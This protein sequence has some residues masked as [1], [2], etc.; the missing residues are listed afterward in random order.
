MAGRLDGRRPAGFG[1]L[2]KQTVEESCLMCDGI[3]H[4]MIAF[5][6][7]KSFG[8]MFSHLCHSLWHHG[9]LSCTPV[10]YVAVASRRN[11]INHQLGP[12]NAA[13]AHLMPLSI[14]IHPMRPHRSA[15]GSQCQTSSSP[16]HHHAPPPSFAHPLTPW[17]PLRPLVSCQGA[18]GSAG[19][20]ADRVQGVQPRGGPCVAG[21]G[22]QQAVEGFLQR[23][24]LEAPGEGVKG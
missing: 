9:Q 4:T 13:F 20:R 6:R 8:C 3:K 12:C 5:L 22:Q 7:S 19:P 1:V 2:L 16:L 21:Q 24:G 18:A 14:D 23:E 15:K 11:P 17:Y 10:T